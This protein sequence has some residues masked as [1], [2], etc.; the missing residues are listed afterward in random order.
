MLGANKFAGVTILELLLVMT[1]IASLVGLSTWG[2]YLFRS[3]SEVEGAASE[4]AANFQTID[5]AMRFSIPSNVVPNVRLLD[6]RIEGFA[7]FFANN[8]YGLRYCIRAGANFNCS[9]SEYPVVKSP[10][11][12]DVYVRPITADAVR[13]RGILFERRTGQ[14]YSM[15]DFNVVPAKGQ[16]CT[17]SIQHRTAT[18]NKEMIVNLAS[19]SYAL[20]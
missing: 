13:C 15:T 11:Y 2:I 6:D 14:I 9:A 8:N 17:I 20:Q 10:A 5:N 16:P 18:T 7:F 1:V 19:N 12:A 3:V 4:M